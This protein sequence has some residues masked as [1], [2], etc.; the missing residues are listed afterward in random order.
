MPVRIESQA[1]PIPGYR[2]IERLGGGGFGEVWKCEAPGGLYKAIKFVYGDLD[3]SDEEGARAEQEL[4]ALSRVKTVHHPYILSLERYDIID[5]QLLIVME[6][7]DRTLW[8]RFRECRSQGQPGIPRAELTGYME[9]TAEA[10]DLMDSLYQ[11]QHLDIKPQNLFLVHNHVKVADFGLVKDLEGGIASVT[12]GV[13]PVYAA[14]ETFD[15]RVT[16]FSDQYSL[17]IVYQE[18]LSGQR[19]FTGNSL[20]Q[21]VMQHLYSEPDLSSL[22]AADRAAVSR[23]L[24]KTPEDRYPTCKDFVRALRDVSAPHGLVPAPAQPL[25]NGPPTEPTAPHD[26]GDGEKTQSGPRRRQDILGEP[27]GSPAPEVLAAAP[28]PDQ[29]TPLPAREAQRVVDSPVLPPRHDTST[30]LPAGARKTSA[31]VREDG[32]LTPGL[33]IGLGQIGLHV[34]RQLRQEINERFGGPDALPQLRLLHIDTDPEH[35]LAAARGPAETALRASE[36][37]LARLQR[38]SYYIKPS[39]SGD[40]KAWLHPKVLYRMPRQQTPSGIRALGR[41]A[42]VDNYRAISR[43]LEGEL[44]ACCQTEALAQAGRHTRLPVR[45]GVPRV[46][47]IAGLAGGTGGGMF[48]DV[49]YTLRRLLRG[50]GH[51][52]SEVHGLFLL[53]KAETGP[54]RPAELA[55]TFA[56]LTELNHFSAPGGRFQARYT[57]ETN[58]PVEALSEAGAPFQRCVLFSLPDPR[59]DG[60]AGESPDGLPG[61]A[62]GA[63]RVVS[64]AGHFLLTDLASSLGRTADQARRPGAGPVYQAVGMYRLLW[65]RR[66]M[67]D[68]AARVLCRRLVQRWMSKDAKPLR[69]PLR[70]W[71]QQQWDDQG[72]A[73]EQLIARFQ[74]GCEHALKQTPENAFGAVLAP[75][76]AAVP[77]AGKGPAVLD[78]KPAAVVEAMERLERMLGIPDEC[79]KGTR[80]G[81]SSDQ[82]LAVVEQA[83][84]ETS[85]ALREECDQKLAVLVVRLIEDPQFRLAGAEEALRQL[86]EYTEKSLRHHEDLGRELHARAVAAYQRISQLLEAAGPPTPGSSWKTPFNR[87]GGGPTDQAIELLELLR[88]YPK[89]RYQS[90]ILQRVNALY[91][92]LRGQLSDQLREVDYCRARLG[93]LMGMFEGAV[94]GGRR[95]P[96]LTAGRCLLPR[97]CASLDEAVRQ[98]AD[99]V[100][101]EHLH[102]LD[103]RVQALLRQH[104]RA[105]VQVCMTAGNVLRTLA[106]AMLDEVRAFLEPRLA[107]ADVAE[108]YLEQHQATEPA[109]GSAT[110]MLRQDLMTAHGKAAPELRGS[111]SCPETFVLG[112]PAGSGGQEL[113]DLAREALAVRSQVD[114][115]TDDEIVFYRE[116]QNLS[117]AELE[118]FGQA[119]QE[120][121]RKLLAQDYLTPHS[122]VDITNWQPQVVISNQ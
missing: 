12:G 62:P 50:L 66:Q 4:K 94:P 21:L 76:L 75:V 78:V 3:A 115:V 6:L 69:E 72:L 49:A 51:T 19:P 97:G 105:L 10:L 33:V 53:P 63:A 103:R 24:A 1:E 79:R 77:P 17:A 20:R 31:E 5:G 87:R 44:K 26:P 110:D 54:G 95:P 16:R 67:R 11:L 14:P 18:L 23:A 8:D 92:S 7:A 38:P 116:Y 36:T 45:S 93:E 90:L 99:G 59:S 60:A 42:F 88:L 101:G 85:N 57:G 109:D 28:G 104:F 68:Q 98:L 119:A 96:A 118:Q 107:G 40:V 102:E 71:V 100:T 37:L 112:V 43:R 80:P 56:A 117:L 122:R 91:L 48:L 9:E 82:P 46:Y 113:R 13:T 41:L 34:L 35:S 114:A 29:A 121:Y 73:L 89:Y 58:G 111:F 86:A 55:N 108:V 81:Q 30:P 47:V 2:L 83:L 52:D 32:I 106:P 39:F 74:T 65:P 120:A 25:T 61:L 22:P 70:P 64:L 15:G 84:A 27:E